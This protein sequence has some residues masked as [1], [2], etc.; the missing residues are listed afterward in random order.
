MLCFVQLP[1]L[2]CGKH[3]PE[4]CESSTLRFFIDSFY[5]SE[6]NCDNLLCL[7]VGPK[8]TLIGPGLK[9]ISG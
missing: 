5:R 3:V 6:K 2:S 9:S 7:F 4:P 8:G 1:L